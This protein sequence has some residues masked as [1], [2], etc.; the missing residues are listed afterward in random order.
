MGKITYLN[1]KKSKD[2]LLVRCIG[3]VKRSLSAA[4]QTACQYTDMYMKQNFAHAFILLFHPLLCSLGPKFNESQIF[5]KGENTDV[6]LSLTCG[7]TS[8]WPGV[9]RGLSKQLETQ[10]LFLHCAIKVDL[11]QLLAKCEENT[12]RKKSSLYII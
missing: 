3:T 2:P 12:G 10:L 5:S 6:P 8:R 7:W 11:S 9:H 4:T 1:K